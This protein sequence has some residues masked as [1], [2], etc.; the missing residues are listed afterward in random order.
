MGSIQVIEVTS[1]PSRASFVNTE[2]LA[3]SIPFG[4]SSSSLSPVKIGVKRRRSDSSGDLDE[5][6]KSSTSSSSRPPLMRSLGLTA[7]AP[8]MQPLRQSAHPMTRARV[9]EVIQKACQ[10]LQMTIPPFDELEL[11][12]DRT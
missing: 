12:S 4:R 5:N 10:T 9:Y 8:Q 11:L 6:R 1:T 2:R 3:V 7:T